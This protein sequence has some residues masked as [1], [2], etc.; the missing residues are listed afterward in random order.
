M[1]LLGAALSALGLLAFSATAI[2]QAERQPDIPAPPTDYGNVPPPS[3]ELVPSEPEAPLEGE[4]AWGIA[5][6]GVTGGLRDPVYAY[7]SDDG[8][9][10]SGAIFFLS[11]YVTGIALTLPYAFACCRTDSTFAPFAFVPFGQWAVAIGGRGEAALS[12]SLAALFEIVGSIIFLAGIF[13]H[14][15]VLRPGREA[16]DVTF[17]RDGVQVAF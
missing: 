17:G 11:A 1:R 9:A 4:V 7:E 14:R 3:H 12:G 8:I 5:P 15:A 6:T 10:L 2:A 13:H 16:G